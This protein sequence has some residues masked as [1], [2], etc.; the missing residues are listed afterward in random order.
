MSDDPQLAAQD[1]EINKRVAEAMERQYL[2]QAAHAL[3]DARNDIKNLRHLDLLPTSTVSDLDRLV[4]EI[5]NSMW[6]IEKLL[7]PNIP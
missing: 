4:N 3:H 7:N 5:E 6:R 2:K 1:A